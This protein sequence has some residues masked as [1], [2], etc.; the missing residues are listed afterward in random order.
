V[1]DHFAGFKLTGRFRA[2]EL[3]TLIRS[4]PE[5]VTEFMCHPGRCTDELRS[6]PTR[7]KDSREEELQ[8]LLAPEVR[9]AIGEQ[10]VQLTRY[11]NL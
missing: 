9:Q 8:A 6:M 5:G 4:L 3:V 10:G 1:T 7:L 11:R 2:A